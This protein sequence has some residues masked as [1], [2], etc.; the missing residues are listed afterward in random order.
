MLNIRGQRFVDEAEDI[1]LHTFVAMGDKIL[2]QPR[3][4]AFQVFDSKTTHL[5]EP[6]YGS[7]QAVTADTIEELAAK[8]NL[9]PGQ[10]ARTIDEY[11]NAVQDGPFDPQTLDGKCTSGLTPPKSN[12]ALTLDT[13]PYTAY[14]VTAGITYTFGGLRINTSAQVLDTEDQVISGLYAAGEIVG[15]FFYYDSLR[16]SGLM[17]GAVFGRIGGA[18]AAGIDS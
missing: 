8:L 15:G 12:W 6:R 2:A 3:G 13:P 11:N 17:H 1:A 5:L 7:A 18:N 14:R 9:D 4:I 10:T 16:A